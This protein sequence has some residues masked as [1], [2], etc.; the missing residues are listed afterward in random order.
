MKRPLLLAGSL[1]ALVIWA[2][3]YTI[4]RWVIELTRWVFA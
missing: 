2:G 4:I 3:C 1:F